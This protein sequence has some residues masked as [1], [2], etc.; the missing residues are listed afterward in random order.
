[1]IDPRGYATI[2]EYADRFGSPDTEAQS[3]TAPSELGALKS[4]AVATKVTNA[5]GHVSYAQFDY[6]LGKPVN[7]EDPNGIVASGSYNDSLDRPT[8]IKRAAGTGVENQTTFAYDDLNRTITTTS[9]LNSNNDNVLVS[10]L[11]YDGLG[12][13]KETR[14]YEGGTDY[15]RTEQQYDALGHADKVSKPYRPYLA[16]SGVWTT[17]VFDALGRVTSLTTPDSAVVGTAYSGNTVTVTDQAGKLRRSLTDALG[18]LVRVDEPSSSNS[19]GDVSNPNQPTSYSYDVLDNLISVSQGVQTRTYV[20]DSLKRLTSAT[21]PESGTTTYG[22]DPNGNLITRLD[23]NSITTTLTYDAIN[24]I[25]SRSYNDSPQTPIINYYYDAQGLPSGAPAFDR[26]YSTGR[27]VAVT[28]GTGSSAGTYRG[29]DQMGRVVRQYQRTD[30]S[31][32]LV[33]AT[34]YANSSIDTLTYPAVP[35]AGDRRVVTYTNDSAGRLNALSTTA[36]SYGP[37]ASVSSIGYAAHNSLKTETYGNGL[38][39]LQ[40]SPANH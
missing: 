27:L 15:I 32:Y 38:I 22:Y 26:G 24:R 5:V 28:Y 18:R 37:G 20:Y 12:R 17:T 40:Q 6:Y 2:L 14:Q 35:G 31:N 36:T 1:G 8:Q 29:Y 11:I 4:Y 21:N 33:E 3:N 34:Y 19:L 13:S 25:T 30:S 23:A 10:K 9:D 16:E 39:Q 7:G